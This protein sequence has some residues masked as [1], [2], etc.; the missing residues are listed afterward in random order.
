MYI[1]HT[2][3]YV[4]MVMNESETERQIRMQRIK[5]ENAKKE[6]ER[7]KICELGEKRQQKILKKFNYSFFFFFVKSILEIMVIIVLVRNLKMLLIIGSFR[8]MIGL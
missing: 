8:I 1:A 4:K 6:E 2:I 3:L 7:E 5:E